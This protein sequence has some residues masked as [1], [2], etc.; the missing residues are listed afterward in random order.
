MAT[1][2]VE[3]LI[4]IVKS[5][6]CTLS[7]LRVACWVISNLCKGKPDPP[8]SRIQLFIA[9]LNTLLPYVTDVDVIM[10]ILWSFSCI[11]E[12]TDGANILFKI[13]AISSLL[14]F[15]TSNNSNIQIPALKVIGNFC[16]GKSTD[17]DSLLDNN[18]LS[19]LLNVITS[20]S[21]STVISLG[22][23]ILSNI[24][25]G[26]EKHIQHIINSGCFKS[27]LQLLGGSSDRAVKNEAGHAIANL[28]ANGNEE[29]LYKMTQ[30]G[31]IEG[32][33]QAIDTLESDTLLQALNAIEE[34]LFIGNIKDNHNLLANKFESV[35]GKKR[36]E[37]LL[38]HPNVEV[39]QRAIKILDEFLDSKESEELMTD[40]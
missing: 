13:V 10:D 40:P 35:G 32:L 23:W 5:E 8:L 27:L 7:M 33:S 9:P 6:G 21:N 1:E 36:L 20:K 18:G 24:A 31:I 26:P 16:L 30:E 15:T 22:C 38:L 25:S 39:Y 28:C 34:I 11:T 17:I 14:K 3:R 12:I 4:G 19:I 2:F 29:Q 37:K